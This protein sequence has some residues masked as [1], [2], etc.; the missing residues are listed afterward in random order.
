MKKQT[1]LK[2][3]RSIFSDCVNECD[4]QL[5]NQI[6]QIKKEQHQKIIQEKYN[7]L[8]KISNDENIP[9]QSLVS[10]YLNNKEQ[11]SICIEP[12][13]K[14]STVI[15]E[16]ILIKTEVNNICYYYEDKEGGIVYDIQSVPVGIYKNNI[17]ILS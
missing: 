4:I 14:E 11:N 7:L 12:I 3:I 17:I 6:L 9:L 16:N 1:E 5:Q 13:I 15:K 8:I 2:K 10:K